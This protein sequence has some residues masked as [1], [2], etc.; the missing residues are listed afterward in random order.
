MFINA[1]NMTI[2]SGQAEYVTLGAGLLERERAKL[3]RIV[4]IYGL[5]SSQALKQ[6]ML[7][8]N[9]VLAVVKRKLE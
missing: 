1:E 5:A 9:I 8:D 6:S 7:V 4:T 3:H 2:C